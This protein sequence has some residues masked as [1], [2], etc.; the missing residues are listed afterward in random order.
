MH[1]TDPK[2][3]VA[4]GYDLVSMAYRA[5]QDSTA[6]ARYRDWLRPILLRIESEAPVLDLGCGCGV[7]A[8]RILAERFAVTGVDIS[9]HQIKRAK[10]LVPNARL[11]VGDMASV[12]FPPESF[13][14][15]VSLYAIIHLP[16][17]EQPALIQSIFRWLRKDGLAVVIVGSRAWTGTEEDWLGVSGATMYWSH[18]DAA[19]Y[20]Q[21]FSGAG[22]AVLEE[23]FVPEGEGGHQKFVLQKTAC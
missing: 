11:F 7:P 1:S 6:D 3:L 8:S 18:A 15:V 21:W 19:T 9:P 12:S 4:S 17:A 13:A 2:A 20:R 14:A 10:T 22:F 5:D 23:V 16:L